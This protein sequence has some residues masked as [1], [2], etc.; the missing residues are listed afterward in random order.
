MNEFPFLRKK[1][2]CKKD[3]PQENLATNILKTTFGPIFE[4][5]YLKSGIRSQGVFS[6]I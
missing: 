4:A 6:K 2:Y 1:K 5:P 3:P